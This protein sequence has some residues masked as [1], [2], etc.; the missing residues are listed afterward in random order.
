MHGCLPAPRPDFTCLRQV[1]LRQGEPDRLPLI[2]HSAD[3]EIKEAFL[4]QRMAPYPVMG[5]AEFTH[6]KLRQF[7][8]ECV[9]GEV[10]I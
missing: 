2:E 4:G 8:L 1:L 9:R 5:S 10:P 6:E 7:A 3:H